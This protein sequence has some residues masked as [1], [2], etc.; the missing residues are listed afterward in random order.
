MSQE[1]LAYASV[2]DKPGISGA[3]LAQFSITHVYTLNMDC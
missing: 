3:F 1:R 2:T